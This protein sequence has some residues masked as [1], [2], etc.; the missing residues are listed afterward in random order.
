MKLTEGIRLYKHLAVTDL[1]IDFD[2]NFCD[3]PLSHAVLYE[4]AWAFELLIDDPR[5][6]LSDAQN[7]HAIINM[8]RSQS[9]RR[10]RSRSE[11]PWRHRI[12]AK[13]FEL[14]R[15]R[16]TSSALTH[17]QPQES[18]ATPTAMPA[19]T[20]AAS[21]AATPPAMLPEER[22]YACDPVISQY[23][24]LVRRSPA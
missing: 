13:F 16:Q 10:S 15:R 1:E 14:E 21:S 6:S 22:S 19:A 5:V 23:I 3:G 12:V 4:R 7:A 17:V 11:H 24:A 20:P 2:L 18:T 9:A 8:K